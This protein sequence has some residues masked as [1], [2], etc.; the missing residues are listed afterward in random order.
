MKNQ[1]LIAA[2]ALALG[3]AL[4]GVFVGRGFIRSRTVDRFVTVK[5]LA[6][7]DVTADV[8]LWPLR[9]VA[10]NNDLERAQAAIQSSKETILAFLQRHGIEPTQVELQTLDV[11]DILANPYRSEGAVQSRY[12]IGQT[13]MVRSTDPSLIQ[14]ASQDVGELVQAGVVLSSEGGPSSGPTYLFTKLNDLKPE[15]IAEATANARKSAEQFAKDAGS[16]LGGIRQANQGTVI[17]QARDQAPGVM[18]ESQLHKTVRVV[19][20]IDYYLAR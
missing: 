5:G 13:L 11:T 10:T 2:I 7:R 18:E 14:A 3:L 8:A 4:A 1:T 6:E 9:C 20:T 15:L 16:R 12:I 19:A 17:I